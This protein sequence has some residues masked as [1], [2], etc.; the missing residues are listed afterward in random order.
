MPS[1]DRAIAISATFTAEA[2]QPALAFWAGE[3]GLGYE[4]RFAGYNQVFQ[5]L[6]DPA[7][8]FARN[9]A[10]YNIVLVR[11]EDWAADAGPEDAGP[12]DAARRLVDA[13]RSAASAFSAP[14]IVALCPPTP[15]HAAAFERS[16]RV[17]SD[18]LAD[19]PAVHLLLPDHVLGLYP[20]EAVHDPHGDELGHLP[21]TPEFFAALATAIARQIHAIAT[22]PFKVAAI[23]CDETLWAG[24]CGEDGPQG[25]V[26]DPPRRALQEF[27]RE[28]RRTGLLLVLASKNNED[29]VVETFRAHPEMPLR[30]E[31]F[32]ARRINWES[33]S[34][35]L[36]ALAEEL[37]LGLDSFLLVD[38]NPKE[39][40]EAQAGAPEV[41]VLPL[42][43]DP[44]GIP[45][46]LR[47]VWAFDRARV[48]EEDRRR[49]ELYAQKA[50]RARAERSAA[51]LEEFLAALRL[52]IVIA[53]MRPEQA[54][55]VAQLT[56]RTNQMNATC[57]RRSEAEILA[58]GGAVRRSEAEIF[59]L[60]GA[61]ARLECLAVEVKDRFGSYGLAGAMVFR[62]TGDALA[63]D[64]F[65]LSCRALGRGVE[66]R[67]VAR[68][69]EIA[70]ERGLARVEIPFVPGQRNQPARL[71]LESLRAPDADGVFRLPSDEAAAVVYRVG[72]G[73]DAAPRA[74]SRPQPAP[75]ADGVPRLPSGEAAAVEYRV[76]QGA[77]AAPRSGSRS[78]PAP[79]ADGVPRLPSGGA[80]AIEYRVGQ[81]ADVAP[82]TGSRPQPAPDADGVPRLPSGEAA[83]IEHHVGQAPGLR[84][85]DGVPPAGTTAG[86]PS[87][88]PSGVPS[89][90]G[91]P[92]AGLGAEPGLERTGSRGDPTSGFPGCPQIPPNPAVGDL[93]PAPS[94]GN[95]P[96]P[97]AARR[98]DYLRIATELRRP[99]AI[100]ERIRA[101]SLRQA[102]PP[103][104]P[105][106]TP[107]ERDLAALWAELLHVTSVG[108]HEN[109]FELGGHSLLAVQL[110]SRVR[111]IYGVDLSLE[112]VYSGEFTVAELAQAVEL[113]EIEQ[114]GGDY[115]DL[116][117][118]LE[119]LSDEEVRALLAEEQDAS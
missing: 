93:A 96:Q 35:N 70:R 12:E 37:D 92:A 7:G 19:L 98:V 62:R 101:A 48:T 97:A 63:V 71:F 99:A 15:P 58:L 14:V 114:A 13:I 55:R 83:A 28:R 85:C 46:F 30:L 53:P 84:P 117:R 100:L 27:L 40:T 29:D 89:V 111:Q 72:Q 107:L 3:L 22:P 74:G 80:A 115:Q 32:A 57:V 66:H 109:F 105:P 6:L 79:D 61:R 38:D 26:I 116:L 108:V 119:G 76:G 11:F 65:L 18:G 81:G 73:A 67:M 43:A 2:I 8:L 42:P 23:D 54:P 112:V 31:D 95:H 33:K 16:A 4:I 113:K 9:R 51:N 41:L 86:V 68:L 44:A 75:A 45:E 106:R 102:P 36:A 34:A 90:P 87:G 5:Q 64:T 25:V 110:L 78:Q 103:A 39:S 24:I 91:V 82:R 88:P 56:Q 49:P 52:E 47:H 50:E 60:G 69:G 59:A 17:L 20:V 21:Y 10:G 1:D 104:D 77:D 94:A 118:E